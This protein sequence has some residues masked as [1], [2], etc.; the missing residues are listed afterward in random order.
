MRG[1]ITVAVLL[2][3]IANGEDVNS[4][5]SYQGFQGVVNTPNAEVLDEGS[6]EFLFSNQ[7]D[8]FY[9]THYPDFRDEVKS[10]KSYF[11]NMGMLPNLDFSLRYTSIINKG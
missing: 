6:F 10:Q 3:T 9:P 7:A 1:L 8:N 11:I 4:L 2:T 5:P